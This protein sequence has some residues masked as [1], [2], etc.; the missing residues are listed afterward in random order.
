MGLRYFCTGLLLVFLIVSCESGNEEVSDSYVSRSGKELYMKHCVV[1]HGIDGR[2]GASGSKDLSRS[3]L[4]SSAMIHI[5]KNGTNGMPRQGRYFKT[6]Q[7]LANTIEFV[8][9]LRN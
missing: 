7:E 5:I 8:K 9:S 1:C 6:E 2:L 3:K 4:D